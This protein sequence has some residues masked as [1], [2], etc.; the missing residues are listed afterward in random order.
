MADTKTTALPENTTPAATDIMYIVDDPGGSAASQRITLTNLATLI[1]SLSGRV[2]VSE[3]TPTLTGT[4]T[5]NTIPATWRS[6]EIEFVCDTDAAI[7]ASVSVYLYLNNDTTATNYRRTLHFALGTN[8]NIVTG[9]D[10]S[11]IFNTSASGSPANSCGMGTI[12]INNYASTT[13]YKQARSQFAYREDATTNQEAL[14]G[15]AVEWENTAAVTRV[16][17]VAASGNYLA[18][19]VFRLYGVF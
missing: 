6:L 8:T 13:Y 9:G 5:W 19:S 15:G 10:D 16:D 14:G 3:Q 2:L 18:G 1:N 12:K 4:V 17:L 7:I 11:I